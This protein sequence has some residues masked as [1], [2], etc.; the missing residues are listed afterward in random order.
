MKKSRQPHQPR[1]AQKKVVRYA[2][3]GLGHIAQVA[4]LPGF[5]HARNSQLAALVSGDP[6]KLKKLGKKYGVPLTYSYEQ[7]DECLRSGAIDAV[8]ISLPNDMHREYTVRA[9]KAGIHV[10]CEKPLAVSV[11]E[12][13]AM[14]EAALK[15]QVKVM[16]AYRLH[17]EPANLSTMELVRSGRLGEPRYFNSTFSFQIT[18]PENI[19][20]KEER[21]GGA[22]FD[23]GIYCINAARYLFSD[24]PVEA[25][26]MTVKSGD[27]RFKEVDETTSVILR[28]PKER[29]ASFTI[30]FG[31]STS[32]RYELVGTKGSVVLDPAYEYSSSLRQ[33][34]TIKDRTRE[35]EFAHT[36]QFGGEIEAFS[37]WVLDRLEPEPS[38]AE[39]IADLRVIEAI[40][41]SMRTGRVVKLDTFKK[42]Q[43]PDR[44]QEKR[45]PAIK[46]PELVEVESPHE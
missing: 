35:K 26:A 3:V 12:G 2:V 24:E 19:R 18:D 28:F 16:T 6:K 9:A 46:E 42:S 43:R 34:V 15:N 11:R 10:L 20:L 13:E 22:I 7:Y 14:L 5:A 25:F 38:A 29:L 30:S 44:K 36:D 31:S 39:G 21:G 4:V 41:R 17:F 33:T 32:G 8:Y 40:Q 23:I 37:E 1:T 45:K 27:P